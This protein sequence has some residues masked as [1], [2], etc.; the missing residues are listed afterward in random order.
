MPQGGAVSANTQGGSVLIDNSTISSNTALTAG[1]GVSVTE[2][3]SV[4]VTRSTLAGNT[5]VWQ[6]LAAGGGLYC[7]LCER[8][9]ITSS[10]F[11]GNRAA[12]GGGAAIL[13]PW[14]ASV[15]T[16][17]SF[18][19]NVALPDPLSELGT[20]A[21]RRRRRSLLVEST[22]PLT[23]TFSGSRAVIPTRVGGQTAAVAI[24]GPLA[25]NVTGDSG[26]YTGGG[27]LYVSLSSSVRLEQCA[28]LSNTAFNGGEGSRDAALS[29][30][31]SCQHAV[32]TVGWCLLVLTQHNNSAATT[33]PGP[34]HTSCLMCV[35]CRWLPGTYRRLPASI[36]QQQRWQ[37]RWQQVPAAAVS[38][39]CA[40]QHSQ[41]SGWGA[42]HQHST[43]GGHPD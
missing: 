19:H 1:G 39:Q 27:G 6:E 11:D 29:V 3:K 33:T 17:T 28:F 21:D 41:C 14:Q 23:G 7:F 22:V 36:Q 24:L 35:I 13:Q 40:Q 25:A 37:W 9:N 10:T 12:Y 5:L 2:R 20:A 42:D 43:R 34:D 31:V 16:N 30:L 8:V 18:T 32:C 26:Y 15:V 4:T 38:R